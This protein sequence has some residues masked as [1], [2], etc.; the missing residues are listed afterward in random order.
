MKRLFQ[1]FIA[2]ILLGSLTIQAEPFITWN[3]T[4]P[5]TY[6][7]G[8]PIPAS[9]TLIYT[10]HC[11]LDQQPRNIDIA[12][13]DPNAPPSNEDMVGIVQGVPGSYSCDIS[14]FSTLQQSEST[15]SNVVNFTVTP[16]ML[17]LVPSAIT[18]LTATIQ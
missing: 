12:I 15:S 6:N 17:G 1:I 11:G 13:T 8:Q 10:L 5:T 14:A 18:D 4:P 3:W 9:E 16:T 7:N 2:S